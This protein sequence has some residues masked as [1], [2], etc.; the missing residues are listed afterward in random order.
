MNPFHWELRHRVA[1]ALSGA[2]GILLFLILGFYSPGQMYTLNDWLFYVWD[3]PPAATPWA[4]FGAFVGGG[5]FYV[6]RISVGP[7]SA[8]TTAKAESE[9]RTG[10]EFGLARDEAPGWLVKLGQVVRALL[11]PI[12]FVLTLALCLV[13]FSLFQRFLDREGLG[14]LPFAVDATSGGIVV[15]LFAAASFLVGSMLGRVAYKAVKGDDQEPVEEIERKRL[16]AWLEVV[17]TVLLAA[18]IVVAI[19][20]LSVLPR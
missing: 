6:W 16:P 13:P 20:I 19:A 1:F 12:A 11:A 3:G 14:A 10:E 18:V 8:T 15:G 7:A 2:I 9:Y 5:I 4:L 17:V